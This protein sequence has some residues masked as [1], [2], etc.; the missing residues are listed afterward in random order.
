MGSSLSFGG[1]VLIRKNLRLLFRMN[2]EVR[3]LEC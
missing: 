3:P 1:I 2:S